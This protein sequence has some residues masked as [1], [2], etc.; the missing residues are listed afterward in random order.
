MHEVFSHGDA[1]IRSQVLERRAVRSRSGYYDGIRHSTIFFQCPYDTGNGRCF[2][3]DS[4]IDA[5][6]TAILLVN[7]RIDGNSRLTGT[8]VTD[9]QFTLATA[10]WDHGVNRLEACLQRYFNRLAVRNT[11]GNDFNA[12]ILGGRNSS[13]AV[14]RFP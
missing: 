7:N 8:T 11:V 2:L 6:N 12:V 10:D 1:G 9:D 13:F 14:N 4:D 5:N 3:A